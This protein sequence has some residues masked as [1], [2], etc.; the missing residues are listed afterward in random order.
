[1]SSVRFGL[2]IGGAAATCAALGLAASALA[3]PP[4][5]TGLRRSP[6]VTP[7]ERAGA[8]GLLTLKPSLSCTPV[9]VSSGCLPEFK[10]LGKSAIASGTPI[11]FKVQPDATDEEYSFNIPVELGPGATHRVFSAFATM[12]SCKAWLK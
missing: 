3:D 6:V 8:A 9:C 2:I 4:A 12:N 11:F 1:M 5:I 10:N 7:V